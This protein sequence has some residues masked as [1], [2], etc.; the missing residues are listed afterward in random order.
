[1]AC[2]QRNI[3]PNAAELEVLDYE[4][5]RLSTRPD[6]VEKLFHVSLE[7]TRAGYDIESYEISSTEAD[8]KLRLIEVKAVPIPKYRFFWSRNEIDE[9]KKLKEQYYLYLLPHIGN[10]VFD[11]DNLDIIPNA[12]SNVFDMRETWAKREESYSFWKAE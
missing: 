9:A 8:P 7:N 12:Y 2:T 5:V 1:M 6:L 11:T 3:V 10:K 4:K